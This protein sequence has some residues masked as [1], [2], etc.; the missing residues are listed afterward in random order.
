MP[1]IPTSFCLLHHFSLQTVPFRGGVWLLFIFPWCKFSS[2]K[3]SFSCSIS[4]Q[5][6]YLLYFVPFSSSQK[7]E[8]FLAN[9]TFLN[10]FCHRLTNIQS[11]QLS[12][13]PCKAC[14][15]LSKILDVE[16]AWRLLPQFWALGRCPL[17][18]LKSLNSFTAQ[19]KEQKSALH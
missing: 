16:M 14:P 19:G 2:A 1:C 15:H 3:Q 11:F 7:W 9:E 12:L 5:S 8:P 18:V 17:H 6:F 10:H 4:S 13:T